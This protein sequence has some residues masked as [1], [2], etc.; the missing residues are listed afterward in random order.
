MCLPLVN[1]H[2]AHV[3]YLRFKV[4]GKDLVPGAFIASSWDKYCS[5]DT[6][7]SALI[8]DAMHKLGDLCGSPCD[9]LRDFLNDSEQ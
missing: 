7:S 5:L 3:E 2:T 8:K 1:N 6:L 4:E 9:F